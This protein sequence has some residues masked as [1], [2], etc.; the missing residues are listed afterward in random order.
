VHYTVRITSSAFYT[1]SFIGKVVLVH[2][3]ETYTGSVDTVPLFLNPGSERW[4]VQAPGRFMPPTLQGK[5]WVNPI[6]TLHVSKNRLRLV[7]TGTR[8]L[9]LPAG[10]SVATPTTASLIHMAFFLYTAV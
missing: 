10:G 1:P 2:A 5:G 3:M 8:V 4:Q 9:D 6:I 7:P